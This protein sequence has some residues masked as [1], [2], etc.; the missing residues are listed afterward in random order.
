MKKILA[1]AL[2]VLMA[3]TVLTACNGGTPVETTGAN[4]EAEVQNVK[5][6]LGVF[7]TYGEE[8]ATEVV[9]VIVKNHVKAI[10]HIAVCDIDEN[11]LLVITKLTYRRRQYVN[12]VF[13]TVSC[14]FIFVLSKN[15][16]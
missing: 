12:I 14:N 7:T 11:N 13:N 2:V 4:S 6:G 10:R 5:F 9:N 16:Y 3:L 1:L 8:A 15:L